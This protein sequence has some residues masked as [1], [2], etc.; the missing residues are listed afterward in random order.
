MLPPGFIVEDPKNIEAGHDAEAGTTPA[1]NGREELFVFPTIDRDDFSCCRDEF[2]VEHVVTGEATILLIERKA[3]AKHVSSNG[4]IAI[5]GAHARLLGVVPVSVK[6]KV[7]H[8][9]TDRHG[10]SIV[11]DFRLVHADEIDEHAAVD[12]GGAGK[13][14]EAA[15]PDV[16]RGI[17]LDEC[18]HN[19]GDFSGVVWT[20]IASRAETA[21]LLGKIAICANFILCRIW[22]IHILWGH[23]AG[24]PSALHRNM[25]LMMTKVI[26]AVK[27]VEKL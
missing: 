3:T 15:T 16:E 5:L 2:E 22:I 7:P 27:A 17:C 21:L 9:W 13:A 10:T 8:S 14:R 4:Q 26:E 19:G 1:T 25:S 20:D 12:A 18:S 24:D 23:E 6:V 11:D